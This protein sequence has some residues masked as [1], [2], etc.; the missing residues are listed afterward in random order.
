MA[1]TEL[2]GD[3]ES[4]D[5][6]FVEDSD[7]VGLQGCLVCGFDMT[8]GSWLTNWVIDGERSVGVKMNAKNVSY[9]F[10]FYFKNRKLKAWNK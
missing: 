8:D 6:S 10:D 9:S 2:Q 5:C 4:P 3:S 1:A 7:L